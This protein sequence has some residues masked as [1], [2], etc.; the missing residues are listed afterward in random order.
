[1]KKERIEVRGAKQNNLKNIN[2]DIPRD[3]LVVFTGVSGSGKSS[4]AF[5]VIYGEAQR[6]F[7]DTISNSAKARIP[8]IKKPNVDVV[9]G[10]SP[11]V[12]VE[13]IRGKKNPRST[14]GTVTGINDYLRLMYATVGQGK[15]P[16]CGHRLHQFSA[17][18]IAER[19]SIYDGATFTLSTVIESTG[20][21]SY[22]ELFEML[23]QNGFRTIIINDEQYKLNSDFIAEFNIDV[24]SPIELVV[25]KFTIKR[26]VYTQIAKSIDTAMTR[27]NHSLILKIDGGKAG[28]YKDFACPEH[29]YVLYKHTPANFSF[30][31]DTDCCCICNGVGVTHLVEPRFLIANASKSILDGALH[32]SAFNRLNKESFDTALLYS[33]GIRYGFELNEPYKTLSEEAKR[34]LFYG[35]SDIEM[36][37]PPWYPVQKRT[38]MSMAFKDKKVRF[39][40]FVQRVQERYQSYMRPVKIRDIFEPN[41]IKE[42]MIERICPACGGSRLRHYRLDITIG[43]YNIDEVS[44]MTLS[45]LAEVLMCPC[46]CASEASKRISDEILKR[47]HL[48]LDLGLHY[49]SLSRR[50][51]TLSGGE[52]QR[53]KMASL[54][55]SELTGMLFVLDEPSIGL[56]P[57]DSQKVISVMKRLRDMGNTVLV[58]EHDLDTMRNADYLIELGPASGVNGGEIIACG[59]YD[60][61]IHNEHSLTAAYLTGRRSI[62]S[63]SNRRVRSDKHLTIHG[64]KANNLKNITLDIPLGLFICVTGVSG[65]GKS[66]LIYEVLFKN[67]EV[68]KKSARIQAGEAD[69]I[70]GWEA[71]DDVINIDQS[72]L[73][74]GGKS[75]PMTYVGISERI[76]SLFAAQDE[77]Q[78]RGSIALDFSLSHAEGFRCEYCSGEGIVTAELTFLADVETVCPVCNGRRY[79]EDVLQIKYNGKSIN[80]VLDMTVDKATDFFRDDNYLYHKLKMMSDLGLGYVQLG[81][82]A[83]TLSGGEAQ[84]VKLAYELAKIKH[85][86]QNLY[87][88]DEPTTGLHPSDVQ[89]LVDVIN[90]LVDNGHTV[91]VIEHNPDIMRTADY[92]IDMGPDG[93]TDGGFVVAAGTLED[94]ISAK[95][96]RTGEYL[97]KQ[98]SNL[99]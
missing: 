7:L 34:I 82:R 55:G 85:G 61:F 20:A 15:C 23:R 4:L 65:S 28:F 79:S 11:A 60:S 26:G 73:G 76:R 3:K 21:E 96:S 80:E 52:N 53:I 39:K 57:T 97:R 17:A 43:D 8:Q 77:A 50:S 40:G 13:Q 51:D 78:K 64:A 56:H 47:I 24:H 22:A 44:R 31:N 63:A 99:P 38:Q 27:V 12:A 58:V 94:V 75:N 62:A 37:V 69:S 41:F 48:L 16:L 19:M 1:M 32:K 6:R 98:I 67:L 68:L 42:I 5:N 36:R 59:E 71:I 83:A 88:L 9:N 91:I 2:A 86:K 95:D 92:I 90:R 14:V 66:T 18:Q 84:R 81:Q 54:I 25:D 30:N 46:F 87:I 45:E 33:L 10:L 29:H 89:C 72:P 74:S 93:G 35:A 70:S 49:L